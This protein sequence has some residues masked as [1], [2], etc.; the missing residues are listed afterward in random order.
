[1]NNKVKSIVG[2]GLL[3][4]LV[5]VL[6]IVSNYIQIGPVSINL[7]LIPIVVGSIIY[8]PWAGLFLGVVDG[9]I[10]LTAPSTAF[11]LNFSTLWTI[12]LCLF[13]T[14]LAGLISGFLF[15]LLKKKPLLGSI[16]ASISA[17]LVNT[18]LFAICTTLIFKNYIIEAGLTTEAEFVPFLFLVFIGFNFLIEFGLNAGL[19]PVVHKL[20]SK[21]WVFNLE[22]QPEL[23]DDQEKVS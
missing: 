16:V 6:Q 8:G 21:V 11:F 3:M 19:S 2:T 23:P 20:V 17:P 10:I 1:M 18:G 22:E 15:K 7:S 13:K 14:G 4:S 5:I 9:A 12:L